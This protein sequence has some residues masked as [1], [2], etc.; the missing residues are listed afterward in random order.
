MP[1]NGIDPNGAFSRAELE[2]KLAAPPK[3]PYAL[4]ADQMVVWN[5]I[6]ATR[7]PQE[8]SGIDEFLAA[9]LAI[10]TIALRDARLRLAGEDPVI[11]G[12]Q[13]GRAINP[14]MP[15][16]SSLVNQTLRLA[17]RLR[18]GA[19]DVSSEDNITTA[20]VRKRKHAE[21]AREKLSDDNS[22]IVRPRPQSVQ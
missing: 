12:P 22:L 3:P 13:G 20:S 4:T 7:A 5:M 15:I 11:T 1:R 2:E 14:L 19:L 16:V 9:D 8:W 6:V 18:L 10:S 21:E 17:A